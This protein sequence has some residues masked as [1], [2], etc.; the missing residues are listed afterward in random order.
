MLKETTQECYTWSYCLFLLHN[1]YACGN[2]AVESSRGGST[3]GVVMQLHFLPLLGVVHLSSQ[4]LE[5]LLFHSSGTCHHYTL[6]F[7]C[8]WIHKGGKGQTVAVFSGLW[9]HMKA[10]APARPHYDQLASSLFMWS[11][12]RRPPWLG[13]EL[14]THWTYTA[15]L[16]YPIPGSTTGTKI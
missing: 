16:L 5:S 3:K 10:G 8:R 7:L 9:S 2:M 6:P 4:C 14:S 15:Q 12:S 1:S 11:S 13:S